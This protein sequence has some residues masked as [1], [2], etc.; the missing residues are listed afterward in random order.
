MTP[1]TDM[2]VL[3]MH[4]HP[5]PD[6]ALVAV[7]AVHRKVLDVAPRWTFAD[8]VRAMYGKPCDLVLVAV[9]EGV[10]AGVGAWIA[11]QLKLVDAD[12]GAPAD[13]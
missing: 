9:P 12:A 1:P 6:G 2:A 5:L 4:G 11:D 13:A 7:D 3:P 10:G 8:N